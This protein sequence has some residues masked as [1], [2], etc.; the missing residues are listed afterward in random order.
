[1]PKKMKKALYIQFFN[2]MHCPVLIHGCNILSRK[3]WKLLLLGAQNIANP[4]NRMEMK[5]H[6]N[7]TIKLLEYAKPGIQQ[8][9][10]YLHF[11]LWILLT[12]IFWRPQVLYAS[13]K[14]VC[15]IAYIIKIFSKRIKVIYFEPMYAGEGFQI[16]PRFVRVARARLARIAD[17]C[18]V[19]NEARLEKFVGDVGT[20]ENIIFVHQFPR[21]EEFLDIP[22][23]EK[24]AGTGRLKLF[25]FGHIGPDRLPIQLFE[26]LEKLKDKVE[27][28]ISGVVPEGTQNYGSTIKKEIK[29]RGLE[30]NIE[31]VGLIK[32]RN[33]LYRQCSKADVGL[34]LT[35]KTVKP[36]FRTEGGSQRPF[37]MMGLG[38]VPLVS[39]LKEW[40][41]FFVKD[42]YA[43]SCN[44]DS[45]D[46]IKT[47]LE[48]LYENRSALYE[49]GERNKKKILE[50]WN[51]NSEFKKVEIHIENSHDPV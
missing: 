51:Y 31:Y 45:V 9:L 29:N 10:Q 49:I 42:G 36:E 47:T 32:K 37:E 19:P 35:G 5:L 3:G 22:L 50:E 15:P 48:F 14:L 21:R 4:S 18:L 13:E 24:P 30:G 2:P 7:I 12:I 44:P 34:T 8:R 25:S 16:R 39:D 43:Y 6:K 40:E 41:D 23:K 38:L 26:A 28:I 33:D 11:N 27:L 20:C 1:M 46:S 17:L